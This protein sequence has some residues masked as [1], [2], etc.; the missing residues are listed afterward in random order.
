MIYSIEI[1]IIF[2]YNNR[3]HLA[4]T[5]RPWFCSSAPN[6]TLIGKRGSVWQLP[7]SKFAQN[8]GFWPPEAETM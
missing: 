1:L 4:C 2:Y 8:Y 5:C 7:N 3:Q 6:F